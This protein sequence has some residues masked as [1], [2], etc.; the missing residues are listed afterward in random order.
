M[1]KWDWLPTEQQ[2]ND[3]WFRAADA[4]DHAPGS[5]FLDRQSWLLKRLRMGL[6]VAVARHGPDPV[7]SSKLGSFVPIPSGH[8]SHFEHFKESELWSQG[9][10]TFRLNDVT[11]YGGGKL[12]TFLDVRFPPDSFSGKL[13]GTIASAAAVDSGKP[14]QPQVHGE[15]LEQEDQKQGS[16]RN[17]PRVPPAR[18]KEWEALFRATYPNG[19]QDLAIKSAYGMFPQHSLDRDELRELFPAAKRGRPTKIRQKP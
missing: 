4:A 11:G 7:D 16:R 3:D 19:S 5:T 6:I 1:G 14:I 18:L 2:F 12:V 8:F 10:A 15:K 17:F 9:D 13:T